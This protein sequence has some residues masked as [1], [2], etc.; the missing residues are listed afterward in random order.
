[1]KAYIAPRL[2]AKGGVADSTRA[3]FIGFEDPKNPMVLQKDALG[4]VGFQL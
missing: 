4:S 3:V 1:M 2:A